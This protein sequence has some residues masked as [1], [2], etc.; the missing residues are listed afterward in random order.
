METHTTNTLGQHTSQ[1]PRHP[2]I[3][4]LRSKETSPEQRSDYTELESSTK[5]FTDSTIASQ[6]EKSWTHSQDFHLP[7]SRMVTKLNR[8]AKRIFFLLLDLPSPPHSSNNHKLLLRIEEDYPIQ[9]HIIITTRTLI[10]PC[11]VLPLIVLLL[12]R[13]NVIV[14]TTAHQTIK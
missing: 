1:H 5:G 13:K 7:N 6:G 14:K 2:S 4:G 9:R 8:L 12:F 3:V 10:P 11:L